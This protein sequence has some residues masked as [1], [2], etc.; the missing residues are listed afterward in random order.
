M[1]HRTTTCF[2]NNGK[3]GFKVNGARWVVIK[4][5]PGNKSQLKCL[6]C[7]CKWW[8]KCYYTATLPDHKERSRKGCTQEMILKRLQDHTLHIDPE[9]S[10]VTSSLKHPR[11]LKQRGDK[12]ES[13]Y[14]FVEICYQNKKKKIGVHVLQWM[15]YTQQVIPQGYDV[16]HLTSQP[17]PQLKN[18]ALSNLQLIPSRLNESMGSPPTPSDETPF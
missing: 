3:G 9:T 16:H 17:R 15:Q 8:S 1:A 7:S 14:R 6:K 18:N 12:H 5:S 2:C 11:V 13:G 4:R 10:I